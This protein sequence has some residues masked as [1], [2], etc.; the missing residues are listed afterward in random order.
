MKKNFEKIH[1]FRSFFRG[2]NDIVPRFWYSP[3]SGKTGYTPICKNEWQ[4]PLCRKG[5]KHFPCFS[6]PHADYARFSS[7][8]LLDHFRGRHILGL[9]PLLP[10]HHC[11]LIAADFDNHNGMNHPLKDIH[12]LYE[13][14]RFQEI[15]CHVLRSKSGRGFHAWF[16]FR[17]AVPAAKARC[18]VHALLE[19]AEA[20]KDEFSAFDR[21]FPAQDSLSAKKFGNLI[22][23]PFQGQASRKGH[24]LFLDPV[25]GFRHPCPDQWKYLQSIR[26]TDESELDD[27][28]S[29]WQLEWENSMD[30][31]GETAK[32]K[33]ASGIIRPPAD[34]SKIASHCPFIAH[35]RDDARTLPEPEWY[36]LLTISARCKDGDRL[37]HCLSAPYPRYTWKETQAKIQRALHCTGPYCCRTIKKIN[38]FYCKKCRYAGKIKSPIILGNSFFN[39]YPQGRAFFPPGNLPNMSE[40]RQFC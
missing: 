21:L 25:S 19:E 17:N 30:A 32:M 39:D 27:L 29:A 4:Y 35:C 9:Y 38:P 37:S 10:D 8:L 5:Q 28:L 2:R 18:A 12:N 14:C 11:F 20:L 26:K 40:L 23:L 22:A 6:C 24:T 34:F 3:K 7:R 31:A 1:V 33:S 13:V 15:S 36:V 16:F